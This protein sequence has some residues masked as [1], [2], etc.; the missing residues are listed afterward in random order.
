[1]SFLLDLFRWLLRAWPSR[2]AGLQ[3]QYA[4]ERDGDADPGE[5]VWTWVA[6]EDDPSQ[7]KDRPVLVIG[8]W[9]GERVGLALTS[10]HN[11]R[12]DRVE[13]GAGAWDPSGAVSYAKLDR[14]VSLEARPIR[15]EGAILDRRRFDAVVRAWRA[16]PR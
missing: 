3:V 4:P 7:G 15:R 8:R 6:Y 1:M 10:K 16:R 13:V 5:V 9:N 2:R 12:D 14:L 11:G